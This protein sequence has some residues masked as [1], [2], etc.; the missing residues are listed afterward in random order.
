MVV[1]LATVVLPL[2]VVELT[3]SLAGIRSMA[4]AI[5]LAI[6]LSVAMA[7]V[8]SSLWKR[9]PG[10]RDM[11]FGDLMLVGFA[12]RCWTERN[13]TEARRIVATPAARSTRAARRRHGIVQVQTLERLARALDARDPYTHGHSQ[14]VAQNAHL[15][16]SRMGLPAGELA[17]VRVAAAVH[18]AGK[19]NTAREIL[20]KPGS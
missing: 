9:R 17:K 16:A 20:N 4:L 2:A 1:T 15:I 10:A 6:A 13:L 12:R 18:D 3:Q 8:G 7:T 11:L 5:P 14:R 19:I